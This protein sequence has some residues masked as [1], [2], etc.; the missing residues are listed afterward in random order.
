MRRIHTPLWVPPAQNST[1]TDFSEVALRNCMPGLAL[2]AS[3]FSL[4]LSPSEP[5]RES[6]SQCA[7]PKFMSRG[8][9]CAQRASVGARCTR[10]KHGDEARRRQGA[11]NSTRT[12]H[13]CPLF[14]ADNERLQGRK[15]RLSLLTLGIEPRK[16]GPKA[17]RR[18]GGF[19]TRTILINC[20]RTPVQSHRGCGGVGGGMLVAVMFPVHGSAPRTKC[21]FHFHFTIAHATRA[22]RNC[23]WVLTAGQH[24]ASSHSRGGGPM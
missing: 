21:D 11:G 2:Y 10:L 1:T 17:G 18:H 14:A 22:S 7:Q 16:C 19:D 13:C 5:R 24:C 9:R 23:Q 20:Q 15:L 6:S 8:G 12:L 3:S 4:V